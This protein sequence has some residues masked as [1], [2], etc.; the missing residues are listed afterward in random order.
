M[1]RFFVLL[2]LTVLL[3]AC[4]GDD[5]SPAGPVTAV[6]PLGAGIVAEVSGSVE[7]LGK[8]DP[9]TDGILL[10]DVF[11]TDRAINQK[12]KVKIYPEGGGGALASAGGNEDITVPAGNYRA[13]IVY[14]ESELAGGYKGSISGLVVTAGYRSRYRVKVEAPVGLLRMQFQQP[15]GPM[16]PPVKINDKVTLAVFK[17][18]EDPDLSG[19]LWSGPAGSWIALPEGTYQCRATF[20]VP[21]QP[22]TVEWYRDLTVAGSLA[23]NDQDIQLAF[24]DSGVRVDAFNFGR[25]V[26]DHTTVYFFNPGANVEQAVA[27]MS[28]PAGQVAH[29]SPGRY[30]LWVVY[31][32][33]V[34]D[35]ELIGTSFLA[36][37]EVPDRGGVRRQIDLEMPLATL[38]LH[39]K[40]GAADLSDNAE[41]RVMRAGADR[42][43]ASPIVDD[44]GLKRQPIPVGT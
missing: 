28:G 42:E 41:L 7:H 21:G 1:R 17:G 16:R 38:D 10:V 37:L 27:K 18:G 31:Q 8:E 2:F 39:V 14:D 12:V 23:R 20:A 43:A 19:V 6:T 32:P 3:P 36:N 25:D 22:S 44:V 24:D 26:N 4:G 13:A 30:D 9:G 5:G 15:D 33:A 40:N 29:V 11:H 35:P 34:D